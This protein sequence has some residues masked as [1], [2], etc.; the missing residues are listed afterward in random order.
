[1]NFDRGVHVHCVGYPSHARTSWRPFALIVDIASLLRL[2]LHPAAF[3][4]GNTLYYSY[5][6][7]I[8]IYLR[9]V[10]L[11]KLKLKKVRTTEPNRAHQNLAA[12]AGHR[13]IISLSWPSPPRWPTRWAQSY[14]AVQFCTLRMRS[15]CCTYVFMMMDHQS[16][17]WILTV[18]ALLLAQTSSVG[19]ATNLGQN[20]T[21]MPIIHSVDVFPPFYGA[22]IFGFVR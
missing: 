12:N 7:P 4:R 6:T 13:V 14:P 19:S 10:T 15:T 22:Q 21:E 2:C 18:N 20:L 17:L 1:M 3:A 11:L 16:D 8:C 9:V 5:P